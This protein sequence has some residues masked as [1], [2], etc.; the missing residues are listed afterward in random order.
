MIIAEYTNLTVVRE[1]KGEIPS[2][3]FVQVKEAILG[4]SYELSLVFPTIEN[5]KKLHKTW[6]KKSGPV[7]TLAFPLAPKEGEIIIT[8]SQARKEAKKY[9]RSYHNHLLFL[10][11]HSCL[12]L[13]GMTHGA[14]MEQHERLWYEQYQR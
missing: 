12:H 1:T 11:I 2:L 6:K 14:R 3:P 5:S 13:K 7:N 4:R 10:F 8:L 9:G